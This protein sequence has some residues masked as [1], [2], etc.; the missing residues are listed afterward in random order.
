MAPLLWSKCVEVCSDTKIGRLK[1][2]K[3]VLYWFV[4]ML[5]SLSI[6]S[7]RSLLAQGGGSPTAKAVF[8]MTNSAEK[9]EVISFVRTEDGMLQ[10]GRRFSTGGR[11]SGGLADPLESQGALTLSQDGQ[12]LFAANAGSGEISVFRVNGAILALI[13]KENSGGSE[14]VAVAQHGNL[15]YVAN[16]GGSSNVVGFTFEHGRLEQIANS[17]RFLTATETGAS[18]LSFRPDGKFLAVTERLTNK[19]DLFGVQADGTLSSIVVNASAGPGAFAVQ[20]APNGTAIV[21]ETGP[22]GVPN[23]SAISSYSVNADGTLAA[24]SASVPTLAAAN[25]WNAIT[26]DGRFVYTGN[27]GSS[28][29]SG[30][31]IGSNGA[32]SA[33]TGTVVG[34]L[35]AGSTNI[36]MVVSAD[37]KF[38]YTLNTGNGTVGIFAIQKDG[39]LVSAGSTEGLDAKSGLQGIAAN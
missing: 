28:N 2:K 37:G 6:G 18:S 7:P 33:L 16:A 22:A 34:S 12:W 1:M 36:D 5:L 30:Y 32:L 24:I 27:S 17:Q 23:S 26:P 19:I 39:T 25:C 10:E 4:G 31:A 21:S 11:G 14:P 13:D 20:F 35:P 38:L 15:I 9:N 29:V 8:V 3:R